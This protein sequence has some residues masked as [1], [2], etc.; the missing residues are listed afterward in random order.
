MSSNRDFSHHGE[1]ETQRV[2]GQGFCRL[3]SSEDSAWELA[4]GRKGAQDG[5]KGQGRPDDRKQI[6][7]NQKQ[8]RK[9]WDF[10]GGPVVKILH[11]HYRGAGSF[12]GQG[13]STCLEVRPKKKLLKKKKESSPGSPWE[14]AEALRDQLGAWKAPS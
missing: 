3:L 11:F 7:L 13:S 1:E 9:F 2:K 5:Y 14:Q 6:G 10:P 4:W 12:P 8:L